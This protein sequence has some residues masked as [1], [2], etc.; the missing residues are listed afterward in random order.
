MFGWKKKKEEKTEARFH[1]ICDG[2]VLPIE[3]VPDM[4]FAQK[5]LGDG[6]GFSYE[7]PVIYSPCDGEIILVAQT[8]HA[9]GLRAENGAEVMIHVGM[10]TVNLEGRGL[11]PLV[12]L[13]KSVKAGDPL[14]EIDRSV[15]REKGINLIT[16]MI[17]TN[18]EDYDLKIVKQDGEVARSE[19]AFVAVRRQAG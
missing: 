15:M 6:V 9:I 1:A 13:H 11:R 3:Q 10:D 2:R 7:G 19:V 4:T 14:L 16:P 8:S 17:L 18:G 5:L 12:R